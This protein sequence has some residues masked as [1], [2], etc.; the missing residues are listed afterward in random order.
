MTFRWFR[1]RPKQD[2]VRACVYWRNV[3]LF[4]FHWGATIRWRRPGNH[5]RH[6]TAYGRARRPGQGRGFLCS[7]GTWMTE[8]GVTERVPNRKRYVLIKGLLG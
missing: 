8:N 6:V 2:A 5:W 3:H 4:V 7:F 1:D